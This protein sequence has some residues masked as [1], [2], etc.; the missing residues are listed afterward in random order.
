MA[1][2]Q[3]CNV[4]YHCQAQTAHLSKSCR[5]G[6][7]TVAPVCQPQQE[8]ILLMSTAGWLRNDNGPFH[9]QVQERP[10]SVCYSTAVLAVPSH[11][12]RIGL[13]ALITSAVLE[14]L[15]MQ[16]PAL[17]VWYC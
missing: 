13:A 5:A 9:R 10:V 6:P 16:L 3:A 14:L 1:V 12:R 4:N 17:P 15:D 8:A 11:C 2:Q 7:A